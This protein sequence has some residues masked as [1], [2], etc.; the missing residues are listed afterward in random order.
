LDALARLDLTNSNP[1]QAGTFYPEDEQLP[2][3]LRGDCAMPVYVHVICWTLLAVGVGM[4]VWRACCAV[5][6]SDYSNATTMVSATVL[7]VWIIRV[8]LCSS[9]L[10]VLVFMSPLGAIAWFCA[11]AGWLLFRIWSVEPALP[12]AITV[13]VG[14]F[15]IAMGI[16]ALLDCFSKATQADEQSC[17][18]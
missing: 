6:A 9:T 3:L 15:G 11:L 4:V 7:D 1:C 16:V 8:I 12:N 17:K 5:A 13:F 2:N 18:Q 14:V 10:A